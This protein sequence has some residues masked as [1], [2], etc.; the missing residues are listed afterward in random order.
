MN[1]EAG[2]Q[3]IDST[4]ETNTTNE[5]VP[6]IIVHDGDQPKKVTYPKRVLLIIGNEFCERFGFG[7][8]KSI[9]ALYLT[10]N[11]DYS[12]DDSTIVFTAF[13]MAVYFFCIFGGV[14]SD[15][16]M[17]KFKTILTM[18]IVFAIGTVIL[19]LGTIA[20]FIP[21]PNTTLMIGLLLISIGSGG[22]KAA[23]SPFGGDQFSIPE[24]ALQL[25]KFFSLFYLL[26]NLGPLISNLITPILAHNVPCFGSDECYP[27]AFGF[28][29]LLM[30]VTIALFVFGTCSYT[31]K[32]LPS[33]NVLVQFVKCVTY[34]IAT[35]IRVGRSDPRKDL[36]DYS[37]DKYGKRLVDDARAVVG[38]LVVYLPLPIFWTLHTQQGSRWTFQANAMN[39]DLGFYEITADQMLI[40]NPLLIPILIQLCNYVLYPLLSKIGIRRPLQKMTIGIILAAISFVFA[41]IVQFQIDA[42]PRKSIHMMWLIP[43]YVAM[44]LAEVMFAITGI[45]FS[46]EEAPETMKSV[47]Q[48]HWQ[49]MDAFG[50]LI[51]I[52]IVQFVKFRLQAHEF[53]FYACLLFV[54]VIFFII[55]AH[56]Y[57][58]KSTR[59]FK[60]S[61]SISENEAAT[62]Y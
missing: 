38:I 25:A 17:G 7:T 36:L 31:Y 58:S 51:L 45:Q 5:T 22:I 61:N 1:L 46:Y 9:L 41:A 8:M 49:F 57:K 34:A 26:I 56:K 13:S 32:E 50:N 29:A 27:L 6:K 30:I 21:S 12:E 33:E 23:V 43:Q 54:D 20:N 42:L 4:T 14:L 24:Q 15:V 59:D 10:T 53:I 2:S 55:L 39:G 28:P 11:L 47:L 35:K 16:W 19:T 40:V 60:K 44:T 37:V 48:A 3:E 52:V 62:V 18:S